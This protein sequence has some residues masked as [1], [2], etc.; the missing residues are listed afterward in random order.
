MELTVENVAKTILKHKQ[1][2]NK[3]KKNNFY[4]TIEDSF[5]NAPFG[6]DINVRVIGQKEER[7]YWL[8]QAYPLVEVPDEI[9]GPILMPDFGRTLLTFNFLF[10]N[11]YKTKLEVHMFFQN[12]DEC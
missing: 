2:F 6:V 9:E 3:V 7:L 5:T 11:P 4:I 10:V 1:E 8:A 12:D